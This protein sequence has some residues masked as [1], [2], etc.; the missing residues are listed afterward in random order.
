MINVQRLYD[1]RPQKLLKTYR[2][3]YKNW[4]TSSYD[5]M[6]IENVNKNTDQC[7]CR[8]WKNSKGANDVCQ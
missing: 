1:V 2:R 5:A 6:N 8:K 4:W 7:F 3:L